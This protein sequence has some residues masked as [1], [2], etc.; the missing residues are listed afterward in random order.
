MNK[1]TLVT[2]ITLCTLY[3]IVLPP[4]DDVPGGIVDMGVYSFT[5][6]HLPITMTPTPQH[7]ADTTTVAFLDLWPPCT[8][9]ITL[10]TVWDGC[11]SFFSLFCDAHNNHGMA[12]KIS[13]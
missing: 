1:G 13:V 10:F 7:T 9:V 4:I 2:S 5:V 12:A 8:T 3:I 6:F 11:S